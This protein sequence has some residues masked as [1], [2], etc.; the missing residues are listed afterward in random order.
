MTPERHRQ[1]NAIF[2]AACDLDPTAIPDF[3]RERCGDDSELQRH[4]EALLAAD[5]HDDGFLETAAG[6][7]VET[8]VP[9]RIGGE[10]GYR[11]LRRL[12]AGG[13]GEVWQAERADGEFRQQVAIKLL[14]AGQ[15]LS[16]E[17]LQRFRA[18]RQILA[19]FSHPHIARLLDGGA[20][21][22][23]APYLVMEY[24]DGEAIDLWCTRRGLDARARVALFLKVCD[25]VQAAHQA[26]IVHRDLK[27]SNILVD[28]N[29]CPKLL[30]FGIAKVLNAEL[31][32]HSLVHTRTG[33][34]PMTLAYAS[35]E[36]IRGEAIGTSSDVY[37]LGVVL[38]ELLT[39]ALPYRIPA[40]DP[41]SMARAVC[42]QAPEPPSRQA[43]A[44]RGGAAAA[45]LRGDLDAIL[46]KALRKEPEGRYRSVELLA[47]D[48]GRWLDGLPV[49]AR[50]GSRAYAARKFAARHRGAVTAALLLVALLIGYAL[51]R[52][53]RLV[54]V[55]RQRDRAEQSLS[56]LREVL[57]SADPAVA[58]GKELTARQILEAA[59][60]RLLNDQHVATDLRFE[61]LL[62]ITE[63]EIVLSL[64]E[65][66]AAH[67]Q[68][69]AALLGDLP[70]VARERIAL[71]RAQALNVAG[72]SVDA[73]RETAGLLAGIESGRSGLAPREQARVMIMRGN[74]LNL[75]GRGAEVEPLLRRALALLATLD[76]EARM[77][78]S[79][80]SQLGQVLQNLGRLAEG[81]QH[82]REALAISQRE[83]FDP[84]RISRDE[85][86]LAGVLAMQGRFAEALALHRAA[87]PRF[88]SAVGEDHAEYG[89]RMNN[90]GMTELG[91]G[92]LEDAIAH[93]AHAAELNRQR[94]G[95]DS[96]VYATVLGNLA[97][98]E[99]AAG[100]FAAAQ[101]HIDTARGA[102]PA[103]SGRANLLSIRAARVAGVLAF[104]RDDRD[105]ARRDFTDCV[106]GAA[107]A[108]LD[109]Y[110]GVSRCH[111]GLA[112]LALQAG[113]L[114]A[115][116]AALDRAEAIQAGLDARHFERGLAGLVRARWLLARGDR[117]TA[118]KTLQA[119]PPEALNEPWQSTWRDQLLASA[120]T[121]CTEANAARA[122]LAPRYPN[123]HPRL[124][125]PCPR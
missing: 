100:E 76:G 95:A 102:L 119:I 38:Y 110:P 21:A 106:E 15:R 87:I 60:Q 79:A 17:A 25:A 93:L 72:D 33:V 59:A 55:Q 61:L 116:G 6:P 43:S 68:A 42:E 48:L 84:Y 78:A 26:L 92:L 124:D 51:D 98:A 101:Q 109:R 19:A 34:A 89:V 107:E 13:M 16:R 73:E 31:F 28:A 64:R 125:L 52:Q 122:A 35:P 7:G 2:L 115:A 67:L 112:E 9:E 37:T 114:D 104:E 62:D 118:A 94:Y 53:S 71:L 44:K 97:G 14:L 63:I 120:H 82:L 54:E 80:H 56:L 27:P 30:D 121:D 69:A 105:T 39:G 113:E 50:R 8:S 91:A 108:R 77:L 90:L 23:G 85:N 10:R 11:L 1:A 81:E 58:R 36:Q 3:L 103:R 24:V 123:G 70:P 18:E 111:V 12:G 22:S 45:A 46:M 117:E 47:A 57:T 29:G 20:L 32:A 66:A 74:A 41:V 5:A 99:A 86:N 65:P 49:L 96:Q 4:I 88:V 83:N 40:S 75:L